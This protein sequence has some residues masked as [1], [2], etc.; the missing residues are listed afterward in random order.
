MRKRPLGFAD[1]SSTA[2]FFGLTE[3][4]VMD[5]VNRGDWRSWVIGGKRVFNLDELVE[6]LVKK[7]TEEACA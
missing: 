6:Q 5:R 1:L 2:E 7:G 4:E 3:S